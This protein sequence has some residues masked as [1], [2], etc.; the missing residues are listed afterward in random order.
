[1]TLIDEA[2]RLRASD[3]RA[4]ETTDSYGQC[5]IC[6]SV[7]GHDRVCPWLKL[8][9]IHEALDIGEKLAAAADKAAAGHNLHEQPPFAP[10][11]ER[12]DEP[13]PCAT[14]LAGAYAYLLQASLNEALPE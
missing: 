13:W 9:L 6:F 8:P 3:P 5:T 2:I 14:T 1:M 12:C 11:C 4:P 7:E 10:V